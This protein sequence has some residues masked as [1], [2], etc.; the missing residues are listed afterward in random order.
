M[1]K[2]H[3]RERIIILL[4]NKQLNIAEIADQMEFSCFSFFTRYVKKLRG[5][6]PREF[7]NRMG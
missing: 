4:K 1:D 6:S 2:R 7:R 5:L 3:V